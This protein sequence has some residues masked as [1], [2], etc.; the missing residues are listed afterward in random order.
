M[1]SEKKRKTVGVETRDL[2]E[3]LER[4]MTS[5]T[6]IAQLISVL[7]EKIVQIENILKKYL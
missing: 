1:D 4:F 6:D 5:S 2:G 3:M 7:F